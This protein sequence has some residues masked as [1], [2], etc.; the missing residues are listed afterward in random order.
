[1]QSFGL[2]EDADWH[3]YDVRADTT[4]TKFKVRRQGQVYGAFELP[5]LGT[6]NVRNALAALAIGAEVGLSA[7]AIAE[8]FGLLLAGLDRM[9]ISGRERALIVTKLQEASF[10]AK[11]AIAIQL[12]N[13]KGYAPH[14][15]VMDQDE[16]MCRNQGCTNRRSPVCD[17]Q[18]NQD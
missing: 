18:Q 9:G 1:M 5:L 16:T 15:L 11:R 3:A 10:F 6:Y 17:G 4:A 8:G 13:Q 7:E 2:S 14:D 12:E